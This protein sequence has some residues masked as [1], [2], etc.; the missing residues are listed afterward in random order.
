MIRRE[1]HDPDI[2][3]YSEGIRM[4]DNTLL[5]LINDILDLSKL[6]AGK[7]EI[8]PAEYDLVSILNDLVNMIQVRTEE[9]NLALKIN[10]DSE[11][12][13]R[14]YGDDLRIKQCVINLL[15]NAVKYTPKGMIT[16]TVGYETCEDN[17]KQILLKISVEDTGSGIKQE[18]IDKLFIAFKRLEEKKNRNIEGSGLG[19]S[20]TQSLL[21]LMGS[22]L[23]V[24]SEY[25]KGSVFSFAVR[26][27]V[28][29]TDKV[30][31]YE[32]AFRIAM[33]SKA[34]YQRSFTAP[35]A[36][37]LVVDDTPLN[38]S[39]FT[40][41]LKATKVR[42]DTAENGN[43]AL[44]LCE[45]NSYDVIFLD[46][47]MPDMDG[48]ETL[49][50]LKELKDS[51]NPD[52]PVICL[53]AN[54]ISG[55]REM[56]LAEG[57]TDYLAKPIDF[58]RL[59]EMLLRYIPAGKIAVE[60]V[61]RREDGPA[62]PDALFKIPELDVNSGLAHCGDAESY[63]NTLKMYSEAAGKNEGAIRD[64]WKVRDIKNL[65]IKLHALKSTSRV[66][67]AF[68]VG[69]LAAEL[70]KAGRL[71]RLGLLG[72]D[73]ERLLF[74]YSDLA[75]KLKPVFSPGGEE[76]ELSPISAEELHEI[77]K[78][79]LQACSEF[80]YDTVVSVMEELSTRRI[81]DGEAT[82]MDAI[83]AAADDFDY[84]VIPDI[85]RAGRKE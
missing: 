20:I 57:F 39:V 81:P 65:T 7:M 28:R 38:L 29:G 60:Y 67:G 78:Q 24:E 66:I 70:E 69:E 71:G 61:E 85:I 51:K 49:H 45:K 41:L 84:D 25:G 11:I 46:H 68:G 32:E 27:D 74:S 63:L 22:T 77:Y 26:Q 50:A 83:R 15:S 2:L 12:P 59:E 34:G 55:M 35:H 10:I 4:A 47:M 82:R 40:S 19:L 21:A 52:T 62:L 5:S 56:F 76:E 16:F 36:R 43:D 6:E 54:A 72:D 17:D 80:D 44:N 33:E 48:I 13:R 64:Y 9:K 18:D 42:I 31:A 23:V 3:R 37:L 58:V 75:A 30:G 53:T 8:I 73:L 14:L 79:L 1:S